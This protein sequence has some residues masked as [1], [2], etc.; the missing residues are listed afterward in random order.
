MSTYSER[1]ARD[2]KLAQFHIGHL[3]LEMWRAHAKYETA[4][5]RVETNDYPS[6]RMLNELEE[7]GKKFFAARDEFRRYL[8]KGLYYEHPEDWLRMRHDVS[9]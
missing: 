8:E 6:Q 2:E 4:T 7:A 9:V 3:Y 1:V 5:I